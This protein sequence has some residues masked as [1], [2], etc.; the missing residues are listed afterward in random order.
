MSSL[1][2]LNLND[3]AIGDD[4]ARAI[5]AA[6]PRTQI[7]WIFLNRNSIND[8]GAWALAE[9]LPMTTKLTQLSLYDNNIGELGARAISDALPRSRLTDLQLGR[10]AVGGASLASALRLF[11]SSRPRG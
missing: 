1:G 9:A 5:S 8:A 6:L 2:K 11:F 3:N 7:A 4:G 10:N